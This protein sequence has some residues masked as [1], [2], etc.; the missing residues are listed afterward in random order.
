MFTLLSVTHLVPPSLSYIMVRLS[1]LKIYPQILCTYFSWKTRKEEF[2]K[3]TGKMVWSG[4]IWPS[5]G[6]GAGVFWTVMSLRVHTHPISEMFNIHKREIGL[7]ISVPA[8]DLMEKMCKYHSSFL[9]W[10]KF[11]F[12][13]FSYFTT[14]HIKT[15]ISFAGQYKDLFSFLVYIINQY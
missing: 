14:V 1:K 7:Q 15:R 13:A 12:P 5:I 8:M 2:L 10:F 9:M 6:V 3:P 4:L 11:L